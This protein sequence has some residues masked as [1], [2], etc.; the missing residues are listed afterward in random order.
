[1]K[2]QLF[3]HKF[4]KPAIWTI[5][6]SFVCLAVWIEILTEKNVW[7]EDTFWFRA[8]MFLF[9]F[10]IQGALF[11]LVFSKEKVEDEYITQLRLE[12]VSIVAMICFCLVVLVKLAQAVMPLDLYRQFYD[13]RIQ[14]LEKSIFWLPIIYFCIFKYKLKHQK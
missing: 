12:S 9:V 10:L 1:M 7:P 4:Q 2:T 8:V 11:V 5:V 3:P 14:I 6:L 13:L